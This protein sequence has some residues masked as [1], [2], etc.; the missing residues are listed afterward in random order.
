MGI[1]GF[2]NWRAAAIIGDMVV[3]KCGTIE[4]YDFSTKQT[5]A[6]QLDDRIG[7]SCC[8]RRMI[9]YIRD[10]FCGFG[11]SIPLL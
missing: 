10:C 5:I 11:Y 4:E 9:E 7:S 2:Q 1:I 6:G 3:D 8:I